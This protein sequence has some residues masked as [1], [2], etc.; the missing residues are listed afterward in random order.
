MFTFNNAKYT[1]S[2]LTSNVGHLSP[3]GIEITGLNQS[4]GKKSDVF[5][6]KNMKLFVQKFS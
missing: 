3:L 2:K 5:K 1:L 4:M 6:Q